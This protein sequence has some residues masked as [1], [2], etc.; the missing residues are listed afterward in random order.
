MRFLNIFE[1]QE[2]DLHH[3]LFPLYF[4]SDSSSIME[5]YE[6]SM[7]GDLKSQMIGFLAAIVFGGYLVGWGIQGIV[8]KFRR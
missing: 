2:G 3:D 8:N 5:S 7:K 4:A 1:N 6:K